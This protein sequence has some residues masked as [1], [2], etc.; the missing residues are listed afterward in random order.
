MSFDFVAVVDLSVE[1]MLS[2]HELNHQ[3]QLNYSFFA[4][5]QRHRLP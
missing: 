5:C 1:S 2:L 4:Y 3:Y